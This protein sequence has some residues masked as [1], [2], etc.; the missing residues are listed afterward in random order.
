MT[1]NKSNKNKSL[2]LPAVNV[3]ALICSVG[4][5]TA[6]GNNL[7]VNS[8]ADTVIPG[9]TQ[10]TLRE[11]VAN[12]NSD[13]DTSGGDCLSGLGA[14]TISFTTDGNL[15][16]SSALTINDIAGITLDGSG[17]RITLNGNKAVRVLTVNQ[18]ATLTVKNLTVVDGYTVN[19]AFGGG[20]GGGIVNNRGFLNVIGCT[21]SGNS[22]TGRGGAIANLSSFD[23]PTAN[24]VLN[25]TNSTFTG[26][27]AF[28][29]GAI[30]N[31]VN[32]TF[33]LVNSTVIGNS[34]IRPLCTG[35]CAQVMPGVGG[36]DNNSVMTLHNNIV[37]G[38][39]TIFVGTTTNTVSPSDIGGSVNTSSSSNLIGS[40]DT[41]SYGIQNGV[42]GN[43][44]GID[45]NTVLN[46]TLAN[47]GGQTQT[48]AL[49]ANSIALNI[50]TAANCPATDQRGVSRPQG[51]GCDI[52]AFETEFGADLAITQTAAPNP[53]MVRDALTWTIT[54]T[55]HGAA[56]ATDVSVVD[57]LPTSGLSSISARTSQGSCGVAS[58]GKMTCNLGDL[59]NA[60][61]ATVT[62]SGIPTITGTLTNQAKVSGSQP[63]NQLANNTSTQAA[64]VHALL[65][66]GLKPTIVGT[67]GANT[68]KGTKGRDVI[69]GLGG[70]DIITGGGDNDIICGGEGNDSINGEGGNDSL[71]GGTSTDSCI[72]GTGTDTG[73]NCEVV[74]S[75]P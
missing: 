65:C 54:V 61:T 35:I 62:V 17:R 25:V 40:P 29:G 9:D 1:F 10:C 3:L 13:S 18:G 19:D 8:P 69:Q 2:L 57:T 11:A 24:G 72:G 5:T 20:T 32:G 16:L 46:P 38:N 59:T 58:G 36:I 15:V 12:A 34:T 64:T 74:N 71:D 56:N 47:N 41:Y 39:T 4:A 48:F 27:T 68:L 14:D 53:V 21:F 43:L 23:I 31:S 66:K 67:P 6:W 63:D 45:I 70:N 52:G 50:A 49:L 7:S 33:S 26:N 42:N 22:A 28:W 44:L 30:H 73:V 75:I 55:N 51:A 60:S 37:A